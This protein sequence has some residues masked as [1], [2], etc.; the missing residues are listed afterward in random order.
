MESFVANIS[1]F[2]T[3]N[4]NNAPNFEQNRTRYVIPKY[5]REYKWDSERVITLFQDIKNRDKFLGNIILNKVEDYYEIVDGQ[6]RI[7]TIVLFLLALFNKSNNPIVTEQSEEQININRYLYRNEKLVLE[8]ESIGQ[9]LKR[10]DNAILIDIDIQKD[11]YFQKQTFEQLYSLIE[12]ELESIDDVMSFQKK[13]LDC[14]VLVLIGETEG[15]QNDSIEEVFLDINF[16]SQLLDVS[17]I[18]K[19]YCFKNYFPSNHNE[20]K[21]QWTEI[22]KYTKYFEKFGYKD[23]KDTSEYL[24]HYLLSKPDSYD[25]TANLSPRGRHYLEGKNNTETKALLQDMAEYGK[26]IFIFSENLSKDTYT[27]EDICI[28]AKKHKN[29]VNNLIKMR[30]M[31][32]KILFYQS[33]QYYKFPFLMFV[34]YLQGKNTL[35]EQ[36]S[37]DELKKFISNYY[38][39]A[40]LFINDSRSKNKS[41]IDH[42][43]FSELYSNSKNEREKVQGILL[44][45]N[46]IKK[47]YI[48]EYKHFKTFSVENAYVFYSITD[49]YDSSKNFISKIYSL[50]EYNKEHFLVHDNSNMNIDWVDGKNSFTFSLKH[51]LGK[52]E[53]ENYKG[54]HHRRQTSNYLILPAGLNENLG[55]DDI[56]E[57][58]RQIRE[59]YKKTSIPTHVKIFIDHIENMES[60]KNLKILKEKNETLDK[61]KEYYK[62]FI[63]DYFS[64][65]QNRNLYLLLEET[66]RKAFQNN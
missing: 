3:I 57:K 8:N 50:P 25:I 9:Y 46:K 32:K 33:A 36:I 41:A 39:Y 4:K 55:H 54:I 24:Y 14:Q 30:H 47:E 49:N 34:K 45:I 10:E 66:F 23:S 51:L 16:K 48:K 52:L 62:T 53:G 35:K 17:D 11:I 1:E 65:D 27:F 60:Y 56:I 29:E 26:N 28:D 22:R 43:I 6:Q 19:G 64:E 21:E 44:A 58:I 2:L 12:Q 15:K 59:Y 61:I 37:F 13:V 42:T 18:F 7:T 5:Q 63:D 20:L 31:S 40:F 38:V